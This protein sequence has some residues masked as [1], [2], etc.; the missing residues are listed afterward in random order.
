MIKF[1][2]H[3]HSNESAYK[4]NGKIVSKSTPENIDVLLEKLND[5][6]VSLFS[7]TD[8]NRFNAELYAKIDNIMS[9]KN[10]KYKNVKG[11][12]AGVE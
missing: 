12:V 6:E 8:H 7:I 2:L 10:Y 5:H 1:D 4:E 9:S 11:I 3:I